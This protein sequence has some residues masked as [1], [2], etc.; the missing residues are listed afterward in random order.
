MIKQGLFNKNKIKRL[1]MMISPDC[2]KSSHNN[3]HIDFETNQKCECSCHASKITPS[4]LQ[5]EKDKRG[6]TREE[7]LRAEG[8]P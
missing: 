5:Q 4:M 7:E 1:T 2:R 3:C 8:L 6:I